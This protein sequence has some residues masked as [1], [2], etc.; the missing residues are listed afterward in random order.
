MKRYILS[1]LCLV[2]LL[3]AGS[4]VRVAPVA[5]A[6]VRGPVTLDAQAQCPLVLDGSDEPYEPANLPKHLSWMCKVT[7][8]AN[9]VTAS[10]G[11]D[12]LKL[13]WGITYAYS[14]G[15]HPGMFKYGIGNTGF[16]VAE[17]NSGQ[18]LTGR[19]GRGYL[20]ETRDRVAA[21]TGLP[22]VYRVVELYALS[23]CAWHLRAVRGPASV[24]SKY[25][26]SLPAYRQW[27]MKLGR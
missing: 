12:P 25:V 10:I 16:D 6:Q 1:L 2:S 11:F 5:R 19:R 22:A 20:M 13:P 23:G 17:S 27:H 26:P 7:R 24:V 8:Y 9:G 14:C 3:L 18:W 21:L 4:W 15:Q